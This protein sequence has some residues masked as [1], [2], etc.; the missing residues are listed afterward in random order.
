MFVARVEA[1]GFRDR[2]DLSRLLVRA[3]P[4]LVLVGFWELLAELPGAVDAPVVLDLVA[5]RIVECLFQRDRDAV[6][7]ARR[8]LHLCRRADHFL[9][10][11]ERQRHLLVSC[12]LMAGFECAPDAPIDVVAIS[13]HPLP[14][15]ARARRQ[16]WRFVAGGVPWPWRRPEAFEQ[17]LLRACSEAR[18]DARLTVLEGPYVYDAGVAR[19]SLAPL[20]DPRVTRS[21]L[22][23]YGE[24]ERLFRE[25]CDVGL[26]LAERNLEREYSASFRSV[27]WL[28]C[29][30]PVICNDYLELAGHVRACDAGW[31]VSSPDDLLRVARELKRSPSALGRKRAGA[32][33]LVAE[34]FHYRRTVVPLVRYLHSPR[35]ARRGASLLPPPDEKA[36]R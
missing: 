29:G 2:E 9:C 28:R 33:R 13:A 16:A 3:S 15:R 22:L 10:G 27:E 4:D 19:A 25:E 36:R 8:F 35:R 1:R 14:A 34:R 12:L 7:E 26:E 11:S 32:R 24:M 5:P 18:L 17:A 31:V 20:A 30:V 21:P 23:P 6:Q